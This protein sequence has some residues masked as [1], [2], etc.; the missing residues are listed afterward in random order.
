MLLES[1]LADLFPLLE[2]ESVKGKAEKDAPFG[3]PIKNALNYVLQLAKDKGFKTNNF[4]NYIGEVVFGKGE[5]F[6]V[7]CHLD[8]VPVG[9]LT[10]WKTPP[11]KPTIIDG[12]LYCRG[13]LDDKSSAISV[14]TALS[15]LKSEGLEPK[16][17]IRLILGCDEESGWACVE[18]YKKH[19]DLPSEGFSPDAEFPVVYAEKGILHIKYTI[20]KLKPFK[21]FGGVKAN[22]VCDRAEVETSEIF[23][24]ENYNLSYDNGKI[25]SVG[26]SAH[27]STPEKGVNALDKLFLFLEDNGFIEKGTHDNFFEDSKGVKTIFDQTGNLTFSPN[28]IIDGNDSFSLV[29]DVRYPATKEKQEIIDSLSLLGSFEILSYQAPLF[30]EKD[31]KLVQSLTSAYEKVMGEVLEPIAIGGGTYARALKNGVAFGPALGA[32]S[33]TVHQ[34]NEYLPLSTL[35]KMTLIYYQALKTLCF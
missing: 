30:V 23:N 13:V 32:E 24:L 15:M 18:H 2:I 10:A 17:E 7:L 4:D 16:R 11:F 21:I 31:G 35:E 34:P 1:L 6:A 12:N 14:L 20:K 25:V 26:V 28:V 3:E 19:K 22:V 8:V 33:D 5:P 27:G 29:V 9:N